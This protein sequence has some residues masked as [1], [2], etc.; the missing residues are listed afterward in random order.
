[1]TTIS[2]ETDNLQARPREGTTAR[3]AR[4]V[5]SAPRD[6]PEAA[7][8]SAAR[9]F[10]DTLACMVAGAEEESTRLAYTTVCQWGEGSA[11]VVGGRPSLAPPWAALVNGVAAHALD[12][13][14]VLAPALSHISAVLVPTILALGEAEEADGAAALDAYIVGFEVNA[15]LAEAMNF[16]HYAQG[17]HTTITMGAPAAAAASARL[18]G[19]DAERAR[20]ALAMATSLCAGSRSQMGTMTKHLHAG[21]A[22]KAGILAA[23]FAAS[24]MSAAEEAYEGPW[25]FETQFGGPG[26]RPLASVLDRLDGPPALLRHGLWVKPYPCC[27]SAHRPIDAARALKDEEG[28]DPARIARVEVTLSEIAKGNLF[29]PEPRLPHEAR[30]SLNHCVA[31]ALAKGRVEPADFMA[32]TIADPGIAG[33][34]CRVTSEIDPDQPGS[35][36]PG[37]ENGCARVTV[38]LDDGR[39]LAREVAAPRGHPD[40]PLDDA[41]LEAKARACARGQLADDAAGRLIATCLGLEAELNLHGLARLLKGEATTI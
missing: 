26:A 33:L 19:L 11:T 37:R 13:D 32:E 36:A 14:D 28:I 18:L 5:A 7:R 31:V 16:G 20:A 21:F 40:R 3:L 1:M 30:F 15:L 35:A 39:K 23:G 17:W 24:G 6:W 34:R 25:G 22:A 27:A 4:H 29:Y 12:Y 9:A 41:E 2:R 38:T 10:L 8:D